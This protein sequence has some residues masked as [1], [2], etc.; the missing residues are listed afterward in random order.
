MLIV[1]FIVLLLLGFVA[2]SM[3]RGKAIGGS[4]KV[5]GRV[6]AV[7]LV[8]PV[9]I[10]GLGSM[11]VHLAPGWYV[12]VP[13]CCMLIGLTIVTWDV[14]PGGI[15]WMFLDAGYKTWKQ[16]DVRVIGCGREHSDAIERQQETQSA[17]H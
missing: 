6:A 4:F 16:K 7:L 2:L 8:G 14:T 3:V 9:A 15:V 10:I 1:S 17:E 11:C 5:I 13:V 12:L